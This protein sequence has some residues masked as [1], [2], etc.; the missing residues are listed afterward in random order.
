MAK[1]K[2]RVVTRKQ[3]VRM[4]KARR[5]ERVLMVIGGLVIASVIVILG[6][7]F[8]QVNIGKYRAPVAVVNGVSITTKAYQ[9]M[10]RYRRLVLG[11]YFR[12]L[13]G[14]LNQPGSQDF[15]TQYLQVDLPQQ[16][17][18]QM[19]NDE[20]L[21]QGAKRT[22]VTVSREETD[23]RIKKQFEPVEDLSTASDVITGTVPTPT[24][25]S[26]EERYH[27]YLDQLKT[28]AGFSEADYRRTIEVALLEEKIRAYLRQDLPTAEEQVHV[29]HIL[30]ETEEEATDVLGRLKAGEDFATLAQELSIDSSS[31]DKGGDLGWFPR[32]EHDPAFDNAV[33][34]LAP[35]QIG[36][37]VKTS[38]GY[39]VVEVLDPV[40]VRELDTDHLEAR[41]DQRY[42][43]WLDDQ[44][45][46][47]SGVE[48]FWSEE[49]VPPL[50]E[51]GT[52][53]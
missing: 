29:R 34:G 52:G 53:P 12:S 27:N 41:L 22:G 43:K 48:T 30:V 47:G 16:V 45:E 24:P 3:R 20:L 42:G 38:E 31:K 14:S 17:L 7:G 13:Q 1:K 23:A 36:D 26:F 10:V 6:F 49:V 46:V 2:P 28:Q 32:G 51:G 5:Q 18:T 9:K 4:E 33:F 25:L 39:H 21:R 15:L 40:E 37:I 8:Y 44:R 35:G 11:A 19:I 50:E